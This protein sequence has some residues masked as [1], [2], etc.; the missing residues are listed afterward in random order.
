M[1]RYQQ[2]SME[3]YYKLSKFHRLYGIHMGI[4]VVLFCE[5]TGDHECPSACSWHFAKLY[6]LQINSGAL[7]N[8]LSKNAG[9]CIATSFLT[10]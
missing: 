10:R 7:K 6:F 2:T 5:M 9:A 3:N 4:F 8:L 1:E